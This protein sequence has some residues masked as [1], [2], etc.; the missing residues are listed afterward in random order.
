V[1][2]PVSRDFDFRLKSK[3]AAAKIKYSY[4]TAVWVME[5]TFKYP[6]G[7]FE[8]PQIQK[9]KKRQHVEHFNAR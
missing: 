7:D 4:R 1:P 2:L 5:D 9:K 3:M 8:C 6:V